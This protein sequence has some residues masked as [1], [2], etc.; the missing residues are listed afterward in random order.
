MNLAK[1][2]ETYNTTSATSTA[3]TPTTSATVPTK[4]P[5]GENQK[6]VFNIIKTLIAD[7][8]MAPAPVDELRKPSYANANF[9]MP[10]YP[11]LLK[12]T[13]LPFYGFER[14][15][16]YK[17]GIKINGEIYLVCSQWIPERIAKLN[18]WHNGL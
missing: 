11:I 4:T 12:E 15:G 13:D 16:F 17:T 7:G 2:A 5:K 8:K 3:T 1:L 9:G 14:C 10:K 6:I 18:A